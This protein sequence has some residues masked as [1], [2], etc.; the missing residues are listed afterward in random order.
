VNQL[1]ATLMRLSEMVGAS[2]ARSAV[3]RA[4]DCNSNCATKISPRS[5]ARILC[6]LP[7]QLDGEIFEQIRE[8]FRKNW[9][10]GMQVRL[11]GVQASSFTSQPGQ[12]NLTRRRTPAALERRAG[13][14]RPTAR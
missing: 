4:H 6:R 7:T 3:A 9:K 2:P 12:I 1:E 8:L 10:Q 5:P 14:R 13:R 11:L